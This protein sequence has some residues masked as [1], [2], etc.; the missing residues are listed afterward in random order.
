MPQWP[1]YYTLRKD[2]MAEGRDDDF[3]WVAKYIREAGYTTRWHGRKFIE[4]AINERHYWT[5]GAPITYGATDLTVDTSL[6]NRAA[7]QWATPYDAI[8][9]DYDA[10]YQGPSY[11]EEERQVF[12][13]VGDC[14]GLDVLDVGCGTGLALNY[15]AEHCQ[16]TGIDPSAHMVQKL[17]EQWEG[18]LTWATPLSAFVGPSTAHGGPSRYD[19]VL[20]LFGVGSYLSPAELARIPTLLNPGG[21]AHV[22]FV[23]PNYVPETHAKCGVALPYRTWTPELFPGTPTKI[24]QHHVLVTTP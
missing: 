22:M 16:Y 21:K 23:E 17:R 15:L 4:L 19:R 12:E 10:L 18:V 1:H 5:M 13:V 11:R 20:A 14:A 8:A 7:H 6:I 9:G 24:G 2:W 3:V